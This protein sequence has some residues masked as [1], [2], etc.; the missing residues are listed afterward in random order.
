MLDTIAINLPPVDYQIKKPEKFNPHAGAFSNPM[1]GNNGLAKATCNP[2]KKEQAKGYHPRLTLYKRPYVG[3]HATWL[4]IEF[5]APKLVFGNNFEEL[6][7]TQD[8]SH[9]IDALHAALARMG[10]ATT[11][12]KLLNAS[13]SATHYSKNFLL[14]RST[15]C[16]IIINMLGRM[17]VS[18]KLDLNQTNFRNGG[19]MAKYHAANHEVAIYDKVKDLQQAKKYGAGRGAEIDYDCQFHLLDGNN[20]PEVLR[21]EARLK[22]AKLKQLM[23]ALAISRDTTLKGVF[24]PDLSR[25]ILMHHW[26][27]ITKGLHLMNLNANDC[28]QLILNI[29]R[30]HPNKRQT[31]VLALVG[32]VQA[33]QSVGVRGARVLL[34]LTPAQFYRLN[35][36]A[37]K[38]E[39]GHTSP[40][41]IILSS[42]KEQL[43]KFVPLVRQDLAGMGLLD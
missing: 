36:D 18:T 12:E 2:T 21:L 43:G 37:K 38:L 40:C 29:R 8:L 4:K 9:V 33:C 10:V 41:F 20:Y 11:K 22:S 14:D 28:E 34:G 25:A 3:G 39:Q 42:V 16:H 1:F 32:F 24:C 26:Q 35:A 31:S 19:Q 23:K 17:N 5:S 13:I 7:D 6:R 15:P 30:Q 27:E